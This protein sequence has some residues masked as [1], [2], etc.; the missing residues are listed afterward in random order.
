MRAQRARQRYVREGAVVFDLGVFGRDCAML[1][2]ERARAM[3][4]PAWHAQPVCKRVFA[5]DIVAHVSPGR[6]TP[7]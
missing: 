3:T 4:H 5:R 6:A 1:D 7:P 2:F